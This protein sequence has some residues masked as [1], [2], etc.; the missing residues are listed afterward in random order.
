[1]STA[2]T[3]VLLNAHGRFTLHT[4]V[5]LEIIRLEPGRGPLTGHL[6]G[7]YPIYQ[8]VETESE[9][10]FGCLQLDLEPWELDEL[11]P[12][13]VLECGDE[14]DCLDD[15]DELDGLDALAS[16]GQAGEQD[17]QAAKP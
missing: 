15:L 5:R 8:C 12:E 17:E 2:P 14:L 7:I 11:F 9:R 6:A 13:I 10:I 3:A 1:M 16:A 4:C